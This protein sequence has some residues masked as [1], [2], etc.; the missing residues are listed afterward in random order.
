MSEAELAR[1]KTQWA[2]STIYQRDSLQSQA[3]DLG[4]N[5]VQSL[6]PTPTRA[7]SPCCAR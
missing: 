3:S 2:A 7:S 4:S 5:W 1:V 6:P